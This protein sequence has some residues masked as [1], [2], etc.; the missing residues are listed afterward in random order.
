MLR[1]LILF[2]LLLSI[3]V[4]FASAKKAKSTPKECEIVY[5]DIPQPEKCTLYQNE[6]GAW[7]VKDCVKEEPAGYF[8]ATD[9][10]QKSF[11]EK[12]MILKDLHFSGHCYCYLTLYDKAKLK[13]KSKIFTFDKSP[14]K[15]IVAKKIWKKQ[16]QSFKV[17]CSF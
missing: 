5:Y 11:S 8:M 1:N 7:R 2:I 4:Q 10:K 16:V 15:H 14:S 12:N 17:T 3:S 6:Y 9:K 13:G